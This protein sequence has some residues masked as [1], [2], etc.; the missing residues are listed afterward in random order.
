MRRVSLTDLRDGF[1]RCADGAWMLCKLP[2]IPGSSAAQSAD[3]SP[4]PIAAAG[5]G[6]ER[7]SLPRC[8]SDWSKAEMS[9]SPCRPCVWRHRCW[10]AVGRA[11]KR[12]L[13]CAGSAAE[14]GGRPGRR[15]T[16]SGKGRAGDIP[17]ARSRLRRDPAARVCH[18]AGR[19][20]VQS[21]CRALDGRPLWGT[22]LRP[23][24]NR[25]GRDPLRQ[26]Q[27]LYDWLFPAGAMDPPH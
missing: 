25:A 1:V 11:T 6:T 3:C 20:A 13:G 23:P 4:E 18:P 26:L 17:P 24:R 2:R 10:S 15:S 19:A 7:R 5:S 21:P 27:C 8:P 12:S 16:S 14:A 22:R 9:G